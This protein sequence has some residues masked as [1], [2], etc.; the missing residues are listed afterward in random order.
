[1]T[2]TCLLPPR[3]IGRG[4]SVNPRESTG[5]LIW[6]LG[7]TKK[8]KEESEIRKNKMSGLECRLYLHL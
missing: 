6:A 8:K 2:N 1:M 4:L 7:S 5:A 3:P